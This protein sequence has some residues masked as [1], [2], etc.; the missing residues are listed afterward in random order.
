MENACAN[1]YSQSLYDYNS[2]YVLKGLIW[3]IPEGEGLEMS[4]RTI[5][6]IMDPI[7]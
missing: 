5:K 7:G 4:F 1:Q 3:V 6:V 2:I